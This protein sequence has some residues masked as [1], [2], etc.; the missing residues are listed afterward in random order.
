VKIAAFTAR[1]AK[2]PLAAYADAAPWLATSKLE[3]IVSGVIAALPSGYRIVGGQAVHESATI[4][5]GATLKGALIIGAGCYV[6][7]TAYLR[8]GVFMDEDCVVGPGA[9]VKTTVMLKGAKLAHLNFVGDSILGAEVNIEAGAIIANYRN[10]RVDK[11]IRFSYRNAMI[12]T[13][14]EKFGAIAGDHTRIGAN[15]VIAPGAALDPGS[16]VGRLSLVDMG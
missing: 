6:A 15:A 2:T 7:A 13:G 4:E 8:G 12:D 11:G 9:E 16:I 10:E 1:F 3:A 5:A 14:V